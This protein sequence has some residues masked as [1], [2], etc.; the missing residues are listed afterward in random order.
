MVLQGEI[1]KSVIAGDVNTPL[2][3]ADSSSRQKIGKNVVKLNSTINLYV[4]GTSMEPFI[5]QQNKYS[6][7]GHMEHLPDR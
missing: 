4:Y 1:D 5:Q 6:S 3:A 2:S 7:Q